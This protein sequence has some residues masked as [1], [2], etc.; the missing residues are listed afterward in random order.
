MSS[1]M[2]CDQ[3]SEEKWSLRQQVRGLLLQVLS[4]DDSGMRRNVLNPEE[5]FHANANL[6][7]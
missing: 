3:V 1:G 2:L 5:S 4:S 7:H 6:L